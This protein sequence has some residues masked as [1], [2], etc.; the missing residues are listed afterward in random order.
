MGNELYIQK[1]KDSS[2]HEIM[3]VLQGTFVSMKPEQKAD[4]PDEETGETQESMIYPVKIG[5][6][7]IKSRVIYFT[8]EEK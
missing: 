6:G 8:S 5:L 3:H 7:P 4:I 1:G 2:V